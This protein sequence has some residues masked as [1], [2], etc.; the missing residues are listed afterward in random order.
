M[1]V[2][3]ENTKLGIWGKYQAWL[4]DSAL[5]TGKSARGTDHM[6]RVKMDAKPTP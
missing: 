3:H 6:L 4:R 5:W 2:G 1:P